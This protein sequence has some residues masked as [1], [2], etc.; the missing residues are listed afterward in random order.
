MRFED[1]ND[2]NLEQDSDNILDE[3]GSDEEEDEETD[4]DNDF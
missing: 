1:E 2:Q 4:E 3:S